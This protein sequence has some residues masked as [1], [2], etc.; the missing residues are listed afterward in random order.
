MKNSTQDTPLKMDFYEHYTSFTDEQI[1]EILKYHK[2][3]QNIAVGAAIKIAIERQLIHSDQDLLAPEFQKSHSVGFT[4]FPEIINDYQ[5]QKL[6]GSLFRFMYVIS[7]SPIIYGFL[8]FG[9]GQIDQTFLG[10][11]IGL[12]WLLFCLL[13]KKTKKIIFLMPMFALLFIV[14]LSV[15]LKI[16]SL[17]TFRILD[18]VMLIIGTLLPA[19][20]MIYLMKLIRHK[21]GNN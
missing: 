14:S 5:R 19:Y 18:L 9:E 4:I 2:D 20:L 10:V 21:P 3:Y 6:I 13:L 16:F 8:Q 11:G 17:E 15:W 1:L 7:F 12:T